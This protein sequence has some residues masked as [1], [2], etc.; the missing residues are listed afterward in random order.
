MIFLL[1]CINELVP[2]QT[3]NL[4]HNRVGKGHEATKRS[5]RGYGGTTH[6]FGKNKNM[7]TKGEEK[8]LFFI[9]KENNQLCNLSVD[10]QTFTL[11]SDVTIALRCIS[12]NSMPWSCVLTSCFRWYVRA[13][14]SSVWRQI[15]KIDYVNIPQHPY[16]VKRS[17]IFS[18]STC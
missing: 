9:N 14:A 18:A 17:N 16:K 15:V 4:T 8:S 1:F 12:W 5:H 2:T 6:L 7:F 10:L 13:E 3:Y 11:C